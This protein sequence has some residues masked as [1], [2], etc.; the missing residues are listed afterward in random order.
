ML[1]RLIDPW[2]AGATLLAGLLSVPVLVVVAA[3][4]HPA[5]EV[6]QHLVDTVL[7]DYVRNSLLLMLGVAV[8]TL[9]LGV[10]TAWLTV[11]HAVVTPMDSVPAATP[12]ISARELAT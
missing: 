12:T 6:W 8:G 1:R 5:G 3:V 4:F 10:S 9:V 7:P 2:S 11:S